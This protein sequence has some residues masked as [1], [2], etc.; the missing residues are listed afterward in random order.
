MGRRAAR[1]E[2]LRLRLGEA[3]GVEGVQSTSLI[4]C[5]A[6]G[7]RIGRDVCIVNQER[8]PKDCFGCEHR[9]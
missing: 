9:G 6:R 2:G 5:K 8:R 1:K 3:A 4:W 7:Q